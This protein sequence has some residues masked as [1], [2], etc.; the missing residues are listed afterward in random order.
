MNKLGKQSE[1]SCL[2]LKLLMFDT[3][4]IAHS[5]VSLCKVWLRVQANTSKQNL[6]GKE[7]AETLK[8]KHVK[9]KM[10]INYLK[11]FK[12]FSRFARYFMNQANSI[13]NMKLRSTYVNVFAECSSFFSTGTSVTHT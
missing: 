5:F 12:F 9:P 2:R 7:H 8:R 4:V 10:T 13:D 11:T 1:T 3:A 6:M